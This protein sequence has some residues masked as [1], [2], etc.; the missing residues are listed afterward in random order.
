MP[1]ELRH[2]LF[3]LPEV[4]AAALDHLRQRPHAEVPAGTVQRAEL[5]GGGSEPPALRITFRTDA[6]DRRT[7][8]DIPEEE[9]RAALLALCRKRCIPLP[10]DAAKSLSRHGERLALVM[11]LTER[12]AAG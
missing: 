2:I 3:R 4:V 12:R 6:D 7:V 11:N 9:L 8:L 5:L 1:S 10:M